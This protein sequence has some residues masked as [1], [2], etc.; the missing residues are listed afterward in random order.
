[1]NT[2][3]DQK[4]P[5]ED[6]V[7]KHTFDGIQEYDRRLPNWWLLTFYGAIVFSVVYWFYFRHSGVSQPDGERVEAEMMQI[8]AAKLA[9][10]SSLNDESLW[11]MSRNPISIESGRATFNANCSA[12][13]LASLKG[14]DE[15]PAAIGVSLVDRQW[16]YGG[17]PTELLAVVTNGT[18]KGMPAWGPLLGPKKISETVAYIL[19]HHELDEP[20][21]AA[22]APQLT[23]SK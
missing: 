9:S 14:K 11:Q 8:E 20:E 16:L 6:P 18:P 15:N 2:Q 19:S 1:M 17:R 4:Q 5:A 12:C 22:P 7:R 21:M 10:G 3:P 13:H 23:A